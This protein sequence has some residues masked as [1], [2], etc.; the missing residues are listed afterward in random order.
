M[1]PTD[2]AISFDAWIRHVDAYSGDDLLW[3]NSKGVIPAAAV[4]QKGSLRQTHFRE[5]KRF[6]ATGRSVGVSTTVDDEEVEEEEDEGL[7][8]GKLHD[9]EG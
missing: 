2:F 6:N 8:K 4:I 9:M 7:D 3:L 1:N 5:R